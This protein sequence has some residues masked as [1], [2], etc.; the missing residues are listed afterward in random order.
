[1]DYDVIYDS[2]GESGKRVRTIITRPK[3]AKKAPAILLVQVLSPLTVETGSPGPHPYRG[4]INELTKAG[5]VTMR[6]ERL[7][8]GDSDGGDINE[9]TVDQDVAAFKAAL[10]KLKTYEFVD[11]ANTFIAGHSTGGMIV[12]QIA[13]GSGVK[14]VI[15]YGAFARSMKDNTL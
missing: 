5:Y 8:M 14:G 15:T 3:E 2:A 9:T 13:Q 10:A 7:G 4:I 6:V 12:P 1:T 11:A